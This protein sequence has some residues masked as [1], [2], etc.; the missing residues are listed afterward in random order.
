[1]YK[2]SPYLI[3][4]LAL[5][6]LP[7]QA[8]EKPAAAKKQSIANLYLTA[9]EAY[10]LKHQQGNKVLFVDVRTPSEVAFVGIPNNVDINI[11]YITLDYSQWDKEIKSFKEIPNPQFIADVEA[12]MKAKNLS[13]NTSMILI[14]RSGSRSA[15]AANLLHAL[16][17]KNVY[18][19]VDGFEGDKAKAGKNK[20]MRVVN[21]WKNSDLPWS[22]KLERTK[23]SL[24]Q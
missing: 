13:K 4:V 12:T 11:P 15:Q 7:I 20:G 8:A 24:V 23:L 18:T 6:C 21:G 17:Y 22:Y 9:N 16:G 19:V 1:M 3:L 14:C 2:F 5:I 10:E